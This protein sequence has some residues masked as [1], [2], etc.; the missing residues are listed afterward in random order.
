M[1]RRIRRRRETTGDLGAITVMRE[2]AD[3]VENPLRFR[4]VNL[5]QPAMSYGFTKAKGAPQGKTRQRLTSV[6]P[7]PAFR[8]PSAYPNAS[9]RFASPLT[10]TKTACHLATPTVSHSGH[11][12]KIYSQRELLARLVSLAWQHRLGCVLLIAQQGAL[13]LLGLAGLGGIGVGIDYLRHVLDPTLGVMTFPLGWRPPEHWTSMQVLTAL[14]IW[15]L[16]AAILRAVLTMWIAVTNSHLG[17][18]KIVVGLRTAVY[19]KLQRLGFRFFDANTTGPLINRVTSDTQAVRLFVDGV[20]V[21]GVN[22][23]LAATVYL[24]CLARIHAGLT[25]A[26]LLPLPI[27][28]TLVMLFSG[29]LRRDYTENRERVDHLV[30]V[31][32]ELMRGIGVVKSFALEGWASTRFDTANEAV[33]VQKRRI[34]MRLAVLHPLV[35]FLNHISMATLLGYG[36]WLAIHGQISVGAGLVVFAGVLQQLAGQ[37]SAVAGIADNLQ[38]TLTG[39]QRVFEILDTEADIRD[40]PEAKPLHRATGAVT[41]EGVNFAFKENDTVLHNLSFEVRPGERI[42]I[43]G[44]TGSGKSALINLIPR[45]YDPDQGRVL[46]DGVNLREWKVEDLRKQVGLVFQESFL[47]RASIAANIA[48]GKPDASREEIEHAAKLAAAHDFIM[49]IPGG[50]EA[51]LQENGSNLSGG[52]RQRLSLA[53]A[54]LLNPSILILD[55]PTAAVD[56]ETE[57]EILSA[58]DGAMQGRTCFIIAHRLGAVKH[59]DRVLVLDAGHISAIASPDSLAALPGYYRDALLAATSEGGHS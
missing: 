56:T 49:A 32:E 50:Y 6:S 27:V 28:W 30:L 25:F 26:C 31:F 48:F 12:P 9:K 19:S 20:V 33:R 44:P 4:T 53:R 3:T 42:A 41:F 18:G 43:V 51:M 39:A 37:V 2:P 23:V 17:Q 21:Q 5:H 47:F 45:F 34:F 24:V 10:F 52:Q 36:G 38:Q 7:S 46:L 8:Q 16:G 57:A 29:W 55:D 11:Q 14:S 58:L 54:L 15:V 22:T 59:S 40:A 35:G 13:V 1:R